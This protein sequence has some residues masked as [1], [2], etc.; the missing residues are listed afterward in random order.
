MVPIFG[1]H[2]LF[3]HFTGNLRW[4]ILTF[5]LFA[6][7]LSFGEVDHFDSLR[8]RWWQQGTG[9]DRIENCD[10]WLSLAIRI[11]HDSIAADLNTLNEQ[12]K[13]QKSAFLDAV[14]LSNYAYWYTEHT[15][16]YQKGLTLAQEAR[17]IFEQEH[18]SKQWV[19]CLCRIAFFKLW[20]EIAQ[21]SPAQNEA[22]LQDYLLPA[23]KLA[24]ESGDVELQIIV[25]QWL[26]SY[27][28]VSHKDNQTA[29]RY[30][31]EAE[32]L[33]QSK[34]DP[35]LHITTLASLGIIYSEMCDEENVL[36]YVKK[37]EEY[38]LSSAYSYAIG[39]L[40]RSVANYF[41][42]C[43]Q[44]FSQSLYY[45]EKSYQLAQELDAPEYISLSL[46]RLY[47]IYKALGNQEE[48][49]KYLE[50]YNQQEATIARDKFEFTYAQ[51][52]IQNKENVILEQQ[53][54]LQK[55]NSYFIAIAA[56]FVLLLVLLFVLIQAKKKNRLIAQ[57]ENEE[58]NRLALDKAVRETE[59]E[60]RKRISE[61]LHDSVVQNLVVV[62]MNI[63]S[64]QKS[65]ASESEEKLNIIQ[66]IHE[67]V[68][69]STIE[70]RR[71]SHTIM[72][73]SFE[74]EGLG[75]VVHELGYKLLNTE[76]KIEVFTK[77]DFK[78]LNNNLAIVVYRIIQESVQN[79]LKHASAKNIFISLVLEND[80][81][82]V[83][84]E[85]DGVGFDKA[86]D[87]GL[88]IG[89]KSMQSR[90]EHLQG[91]FYLD[92]NPNQGTCIQFNLPVTT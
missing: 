4:L 49:L 27:Y 43:T 16:D 41:L 56:V 82:E 61:N 81:L 7:N 5:L 17:T 28:N 36:L 72:P 58:L 75:K 69:E 66:N 45:A 37:S 91:H 87:S 52:D 85:D 84:V 34:I 12:R 60:E 1:I 15:G 38:P 55:K 57:K 50:L 20:N 68:E 88:G 79:V 24:V 76:V 74:K 63:E 13:N 35:L 44:N 59:E 6:G 54:A 65:S 10:R 77:G 19:N 42:V 48:A 9:D 26:G 29:L 64:L 2:I 67:L 23:E 8:T 78:S 90:V 3:M 39:N 30:F 83:S 62:K 73:A 21:N 18:R 86:D 51:Y 92:T 32:L 47:E 22:I 31:H 25:K 40:Y 71:I 11:N 89:L 14:Y 70:I 46:K 53:L 33:H 80:Q